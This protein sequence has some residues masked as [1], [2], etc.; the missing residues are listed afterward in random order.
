MTA[1]GLLDAVRDFAPSLSGRAS[2]IESAR[3]LPA[4][5][6]DELKAIGLFRMLVPRSHGEWL[7]S[8][9]PG[10]LV[11]VDDDSG[12]MGGNPADEITQN[13]RWSSSGIAP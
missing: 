4:E 12:H 11:K 5:I 6:L 13:V 8:N 9:V 7:A 2:A 1:E 3:R 10:C